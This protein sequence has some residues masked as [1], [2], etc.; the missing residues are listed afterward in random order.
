MLTM[1]SIG[2]SHILAYREHGFRLHEIAAHL[3]VHYAKVTR[4]LKQIVRRK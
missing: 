1:R 2:I 3:G 4:R